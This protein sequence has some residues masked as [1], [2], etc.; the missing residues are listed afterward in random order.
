MGESLG[1]R[2][3]PRASGINVLSLASP[4][5]TSWS[6][7]LHARR[8]TLEAFWKAFGLKLHVLEIDLAECDVMRC[9]DCRCVLC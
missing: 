7:V 3:D 2:A 1:T 8:E 4:I 6:S 5:A 9:R